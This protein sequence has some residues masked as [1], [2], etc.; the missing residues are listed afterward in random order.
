MTT[1]TPA[2]LSFDNVTLKKPINTSVNVKSLCNRWPPGRKEVNITADKLFG[3]Q[4][5][6]TEST[7]DL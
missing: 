1:N 5:A 2:E 6:V 7:N 4:S 3:K